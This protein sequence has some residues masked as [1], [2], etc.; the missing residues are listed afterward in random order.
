M[1][2]VP[3]IVVSAVLGSILLVVWNKLREAR[4]ADFIRGYAFPKG[5]I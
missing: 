2:V 3:I 5:L 1:S 4:R